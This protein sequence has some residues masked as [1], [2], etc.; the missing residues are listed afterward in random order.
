MGVEASIGRAP[1]RRRNKVRDADATRDEILLAATEEF[2]EKGLFGARVE[3]IAARTATSKH[4]IYYYFGSKDGLYSAVLERAYEGFRSAENAVDYDLLEPVEALR[5]L[6]GNTFDVHLANPDTIRILM[7]ENLDN[8]RHAKAMDHSGQRHLVLTKTKRILD[9]G[10]A[11][12][13]FRSDIDALTFHLLI[14]AFSFFF[15]GN[16][17]T[18]GTVFAIDMTDKDFVERQREELITTML[19]RCRA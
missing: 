6:V 14:S 13:L 4:M 3:E 5:L 12:G 11:E 7:S 18:F 16:R 2:A 15:V 1:R 9:R 19:C 8:A 17:H 10:V